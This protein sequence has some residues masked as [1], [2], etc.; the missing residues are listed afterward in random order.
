MNFS[1]IVLVILISSVGLIS[2]QCK[3]K[4]IE[5]DPADNF[6]RTA[7]LTNIGNNLVLPNYIAFRNELNDL[8]TSYNTFVSN[9]TQGNLTDAQDKLVATYI[10]WQHAKTFEFGPAMTLGIRNAIGTFPTD[11]S[12][13]LANVSAGTY[14]LSS[15]ANT[16]A[17]GL[18][19]LEFMLFRVNALTHFSSSNYNTYGSDVISKMQSEINQVISQWQGSY[20]SIFIAS[21]GTESTSAFSRLV[22]E[23]TLDYELT[24][25]AKLGIPI[26]KQSLDIQRPEYIE[27]RRSGIS[28]R[29]IKESFIASQ[30]L[31]NG[32]STSGSNGIG[33]DDYLDA[34]DKSSL[35][36]AIN[37]NYDQIFPLI[38]V[39]NGTLE[40]NMSSNVTGLST[41]YNK[42]AQQVVNIKTDMPSSFG[43]LITYQDN[44][45]D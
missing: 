9:P 30:Q 28:I 29:L 17:I 7:L 38:D 15:A 27:A 16:T 10:S 4:K 21:S 25:N 26:G 43:V 35:K 14:N 12:Q 33:F 20:G 2:V 11:T 6:D 23:F 22:N 40:Q 18:S 19:A 5:E 1:K 45:G 31:F 44:D 42:I 37:T 34:L 36:T 3:K 39:L 41:L 13:V 24:K 8:S 32:I